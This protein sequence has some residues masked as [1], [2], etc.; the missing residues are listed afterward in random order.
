MKATLRQNTLFGV[1]KSVLA[2]GFVVALYRLADAAWIQHYIGYEIALGVSILATGGLQSHAYKEMD[3]RGLHLLSTLGLALLGL[4]ALAAAWLPAGPRL[5]AALVLLDRL[6]DVQL[7]AIRQDGHFLRYNLL[8]LGTQML[9][10]GGFLAHALGLGLWPAVVALK[11]AA[12][13]AW[14][15]ARRRAWQGPGFW[16]VPWRLVGGGREWFHYLGFDALNYATGQLDLLLLTRLAP[17]PVLATYFYVRKFVRLP[18]VL[19]NYALDPAY[20]HLK[21]MADGPGRHRALLRLLVPSAL[22]MVA[23]AFLLV[24][25]TLV[26][27]G[28][29]A[30]GR[31]ALVLAG[32]S[33]FWVL[34]RFLDLESLLSWSQGRRT[35]SRLAGTLAHVAPVFLPV[36]GVDW[37][38]SLALIPWLAWVSNL[39]GILGIRQPRPYLLPAVAAPLAVACAL[40][41]VRLDAGAWSVAT[42]AG[43]LG[44]MALLGAAVAWD[45]RSVPGLLRRA[46]AAAA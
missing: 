26:S 18:L 6:A 1:A 45:I 17:P 37:M 36:L 20:I 12:S 13:L 15:L 40:I 22:G 44:A 11:A 10:K 23:F 8:D 38:L 27:S 5:V 2:Y 34:Q 32:T 7:Q 31:A 39:A 29:P 42:V 41:P 19:L 21:A 46:G 14:L 33:V 28:D 30:M 24:P 4:L 43:G 35:A 9:T 3:P 25:L 16:C